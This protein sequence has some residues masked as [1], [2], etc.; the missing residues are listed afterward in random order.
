MLIGK[1]HLRGH[2]RCLMGPG[3]KANPGHALPQ[4]QGDKHL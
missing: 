4:A 1:Q 3:I 2:D